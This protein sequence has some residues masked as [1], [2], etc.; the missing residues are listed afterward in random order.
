[1]KGR[2]REGRGIHGHSPDT[3]FLHACWRDTHLSP[4]FTVTA[5]RAWPSSSVS[6]VTS[7]TSVHLPLERAFRQSVV[8]HSAVHRAG[9]LTEEETEITSVTQPTSECKKTNSGPRGPLYSILLPVTSQ[10]HW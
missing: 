2:L 7:A 1:M 5:L 8:L 10:H 9:C 3:G 4:N 6:C